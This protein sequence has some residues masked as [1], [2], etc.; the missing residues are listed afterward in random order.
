MCIHHF[1]GL[2]HAR[3]IHIAYHNNLSVRLFEI[4]TEIMVRPVR[5]HA[6]EPDRYLIARRIRAKQFGSCKGRA[7]PATKVD[8]INERRVRWIRFITILDE[9]IEKPLFWRWEHEP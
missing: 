6:D 8:L 5:A 3:T 1:L 4:G 2:R 9:L 7:T